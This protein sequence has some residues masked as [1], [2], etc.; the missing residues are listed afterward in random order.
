MN[1]LSQ[2][3]NLTILLYHGVTD[4]LSMGIENFSRKH[5]AA[6]EFDEQMAWLRKH[7]TVLSIDDVC[8]FSF[9]GKKWPHNAVLITFD[10]G[11]SNNEKIAASILDHYNLPAIFYVCVGMIN[12]NLMFWVDRIES[13]INRTQEPIITIRLD[14]PVTFRLDTPANK[15]QCVIDIKQYCKGTKVE[16]KNRVLG[17]LEALT[18]IIP[19]VTDADNYQ[20]MSWDQLGNLDRN[21]LFTIGGHTLYHD[22]MAKQDPARLEVDV[23]VSLDLLKYKLGH[24]VVQYS[25]PEGQADHY[26]TAVI[27]TLKQYGVICSPSAIEGTNPVGTDLF[28]LRRN[29]VGFMGRPFPFFS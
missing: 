29:M 3:D 5:I 25:Y 20:M 12:T 16:E 19:D 10:D 17:E 27:S 22:I 4:S 15:I 18:G 21:P 26:N 6:S 7:A 2:S 14:Q 11:F 28:H 23:R 13:C 8:E 1:A 9:R 24:E